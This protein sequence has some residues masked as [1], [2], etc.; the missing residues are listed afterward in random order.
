MDFLIQLNSCF[1]NFIYF[2][3]INIKKG[4]I[5]TQ[6]L[7]FNIL[8]FTLQL[9]TI[10]QEIV[11]FHCLDEDK[12]PTG[13]D[14][15]VAMI[16]EVL[17]AEEC[18]EHLHLIDL[19]LTCPR[20]EGTVVARRWKGRR[21]LCSEAGHEGVMHQVEVFLS[22]RDHQCG[23]CRRKDEPHISVAPNHAVMRVDIMSIYGGAQTG[24]ND[25]KNLVVS[26]WTG[27]FGIECDGN[28]VWLALLDQVRDR[29]RVI[30]EVG[31]GTEE[32]VGIKL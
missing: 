29:H 30:F 5:S 31:H 2:K 13:S 27:T 21:F 22:A 24:R 26:I 8:K 32:V 25:L 6:F 4:Y 20:R 19:N 16:V 9:L 23:I 7:F 18:R 28:Y 1:K 17:L 3:Y 14:P 12:P 15:L 10:R 11:A